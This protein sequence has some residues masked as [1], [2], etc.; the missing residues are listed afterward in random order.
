[1]K[2][3][4]RLM[5]SKEVE[6]DVELRRQGSSWTEL[7]RK[8]DDSRRQ[9]VMNVNQ[10]VSDSETQ[11]HETH[12]ILVW[13]HSRRFVVLIIVVLHTNAIDETAKTELLCV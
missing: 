10:W 8:Y 13:G 9:A 5:E 3:S 6:E 1:M 7:H 2:P 12:R 11:E 4:K